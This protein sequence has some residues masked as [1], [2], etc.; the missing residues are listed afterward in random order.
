MRFRENLKAELE[1]RR[2]SQPNYS[3]RRF[4]RVLGVHHATASRLLHGAGPVAE[5]SIRRVSS[6][7]GTSSEE[8]GRMCVAEREE[9]VLDAIGR[10]A[11]RPDTRWIASAAGITVD[12]INIT[13]QSL[14]RTGRLRMVSERLWK[15]ERTSS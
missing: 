1:R 7:L 10:R 11:F 2:A 5:R 15:T 4:A 3:L 9:A 8:T 14:L 12:Q 6:R 13:L